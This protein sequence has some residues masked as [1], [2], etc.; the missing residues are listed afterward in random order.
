MSNKINMAGYGGTGTGEMNGLMVGIVKDND[1]PMQSGRLKIYIPSIDS[2]YYKTDDLPWAGYMTPFGGTVDSMQVGR[3]KYPVPNLSTYGFWSVPKIGAHVICACLDGDSLK[4]IWIGC[5]YLHETNMTLPYALNDNKTELDTGSGLWPSQ[6]IPHYVA[7]LGEAGLD[8]DKTRGGFERAVAY[9][10]RNTKDKP[11]SDGYFDK[12]SGSGKDSQ[13]Y[14][15]T[16]PGRHFIVMSDVDEHCRIRIKTT[17]GHQVI[18]D[19]TNERIYLST[20]KGRNW[21]E[22]DEDGRI[23]IYAK[24]EINIRAEEDINMMSEKN[25]NIKARKK[26][27]IKSMEEDINIEAKKWVAIRA[28]T[29][30][31]RLMAKTR[32]DLKVESG[33]CKME[34]EK[35]IDILSNNDKISITSKQDMHLKSQSDIHAQSTKDMHLKAKTIFESSDTNINIKALMDVLIEGDTNVEINAT[36]VPPAQPANPAEK[37]EK[38]PDLEPKEWDETKMVEPQHEPWDRE[39]TR[40]SRNGKWKAK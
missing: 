23:H 34:V 22:F 8:G 1:D 4:R 9:P 24:D 35:A 32:Y 19:D 15:W 5:M 40:L 31:I 10:A 17:E 14:S 29:D 6:V 2:K 28:K 36:G 3:G 27:N 12:P 33:P 39:P 38:I 16:S 37:A 20:A 18:L 26:I 30:Y 11:S 7:N 21:I 13:T 25:I